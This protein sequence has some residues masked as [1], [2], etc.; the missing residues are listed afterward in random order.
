MKVT[1]LI[2]DN[3]VDDVKIFAKGKNLTE[4]LIIALKEWISLKKIHELNSTIENSPLK[5]KDG[6][7]STYIRNINRKR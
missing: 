1:A 7:S 2:P 4:S 3:I 5:F 6:L